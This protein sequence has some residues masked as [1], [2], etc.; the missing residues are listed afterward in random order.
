MGASECRSKRSR[1]CFE[2]SCCGSITARLACSTDWHST[3]PSSLGAAP[4]PRFGLLCSSY[5]HGEPPCM[6][7]LRW[8]LRGCSQACWTSASSGGSRWRP[9]VVVQCVAESEVSARGRGRGPEDGF[10][11]GG[12]PARGEAHAMSSSCDEEPACRDQLVYDRAA[13]LGRYSSE[14]RPSRT[15]IPCRA[16]SPGAQECQAGST[17]GWIRRRSKLER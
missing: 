15:R 11:E 6:E 3:S 8:A 4:V 2:K 9:A 10:G 14:P 1:C 7:F 16:S 17:S 5:A 12:V 13:P